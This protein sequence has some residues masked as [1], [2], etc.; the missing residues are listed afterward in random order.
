MHDS[1]EVLLLNVRDI[2]QTDFHRSEPSSRVRLK[3]EHSCLINELQ[4]LESV[5]RHRGANNIRM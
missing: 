3:D 5:S 1:H 2:D 4:I